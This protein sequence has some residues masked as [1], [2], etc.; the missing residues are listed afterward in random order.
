M[1]QTRKRLSKLPHDVYRVRDAAGTLLYV[2]CSVNA[3]KRVKQHKNEY[4]RWFPQAATVDI[5]QYA[6][7]VTARYV[8]AHAIA[9]E[10]PVWNSAQEESAL[11]RGAHLTPLVLDRFVGVPVADFWGVAA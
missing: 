9:T 8:E 2:G 5:E 4:Q 10:A 3:F 6:D 1:K 7:L 11:R